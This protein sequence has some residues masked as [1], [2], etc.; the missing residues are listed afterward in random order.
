MA[1]GGGMQED[2]YGARKVADFARLRENRVLRSLMLIVCVQGRVISISGRALRTLEVAQTPGRAAGPRGR[3][4]A[5]ECTAGVDFW[6]RNTAKSQCVGEDAG[7][8]DDARCGGHPHRRSS[9]HLAQP[10]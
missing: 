6:I 10:S 5:V 4:P 7:Q 8:D 1:G 3:P 9:A 2:A